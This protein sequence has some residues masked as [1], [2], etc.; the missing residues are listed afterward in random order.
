MG[1]VVILNQNDKMELFITFGLE[2]ELSE[3]LLMRIN[4]IVVGIKGANDR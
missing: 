3:D 4:K 2:K 1:C